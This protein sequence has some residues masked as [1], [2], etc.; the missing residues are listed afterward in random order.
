VKKSIIAIVDDDHGVREAF[1]DSLQSCGYGVRSFDSAE[2]YLGSDNDEA[3]GCILADV[4]MPGMSGIEMQARLTDDPKNRPIIFVTSY[5]EPA[6][7][8][9]AMQRGAKA[10]LHK[11][12]SLPD[13]IGTVEKA[14]DAA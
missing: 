14:L 11:P 1:G 4:K 6:L 10:F 5:D 2:A 3:I 7:R 13:L 8:K 9:I 12:V